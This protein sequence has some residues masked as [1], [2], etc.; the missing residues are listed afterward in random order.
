MQEHMNFWIKVV[1]LILYL[2]DFSLKFI[3]NFYRAHGSAASWEWLEMIA[4]CVDVLRQLSRNFKQMLGSDVGTAHHPPDLSI[5]I[6]DL[7]ASLEEHEVYCFKKGRSLDDDDLPVPDVV[8]VGFDALLSGRSSPLKEYNATFTNLQS[9]DSRQHLTPLV[10]NDVVPATE[11]VCSVGTT[12]SAS[13]ASVPSVGQHAGPDV[14]EPDDADTEEF[15]EDSHKLPEYMAAFAEE[16]LQDPMLGLENAADVSLDMDAEDIGGQ[17]ANIFD[18]LDGEDD[19]GE[20]LASTASERG[21]D[22]ES[23]EDLAGSDEDMF[24][25]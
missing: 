4:P 21:E 7:M 18:I 9:H 11:I 22:S 6:P 1:L 14:E 15:E 20:D 2:R 8:T 10:S 24:L 23:C 19:M 25:S 12:T 17:S 13:S 3:Q 5:D 16:G